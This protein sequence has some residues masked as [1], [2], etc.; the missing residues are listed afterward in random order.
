VWGLR[1]RIILLSRSIEIGVVV[2]PFRDSDTS[3]L[4]L[5]SIFSA[6]LRHWF[7]D[8]NDDTMWNEYLKESVIFPMEFSPLKVHLYCQFARAPPSLLLF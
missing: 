8:G 1:W 3:L 7:R 2:Y 4:C 5:A 6:V